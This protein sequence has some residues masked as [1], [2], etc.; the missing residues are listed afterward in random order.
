MFLAIVLTAL[1]AMRV[2]AAGQNMNI[3]CIYLGEPDNNAGDSVLVES[4]GQYLLM[5]LGSAAGYPYIKAFLQERGVTELSLYI[6][7]THADHT[8]GLKDGEGYDSL[9]GDFQV[10]H[11]YLPDKSIGS[12]MDLGWNHGKFVSLYQKHYPSADIS[13]SISYLKTG[14]SFSFGS[15]N[16]SVIGPVGMEKKKVSDYEAGTTRSEAENIYL[17]NCSLVSMLTCGNTRYFSGGDIDT[18]EENKLVSAYGSDLKADIYKMSHHGYANSSTQKIIDC[19]RPTWSFAPNSGDANGF[20]SASTTNQRKVY[21]AL[22]RCS[23]YGFVYLVGAEKMSVAVNTTDDSTKIYRTDNMAQNLTGY[24]AVAGADGK[25]VTQDHY[26]LGADSRPLT[27]V[28]EYN[29][30]MYYFGTG[31]RQEYGLYQKGSYNPWRSYMDSGKKKYR[32]YDK[33]T[34][35]MMTGLVKQS[36][37]KIYFCDTV[38]GY[39]SYGFQTLKGKTYY[40]GNAGTMYKDKWLTYK[41]NRYYFKKNGVMATG[42][43]KVKG[44]RFYF[45]EDGTRANGLTKIGKKYYYMA[46]A[47]TE[48]KKNFTVRADGMVLKFDSKGVLKNAPKVTA[49]KVTSVKADNGKIVVNWKKASKA[50]GYTVYLSSSPKGGFSEQVSVSRNKKSASIKGLAPGKYYV[51]VASYRKIGGMK[52]YSKMSGAKAADM[53]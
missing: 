44:T 40:F 32:Y 34:H 17:N 41:K 26:L 50:S 51:K 53:Q 4:N 33:N 23:Q 30:K 5:D 22:D 8:G 13:Q 21:S 29:G 2:Q 28:Q 47:G 27:G 18:D 52:F 31:G 15:V 3:Y 35:E 14:S 20:T 10:D 24:V 38:T 45:N 7:H 9:L 12:D 37:G 25:N 16:V 43:N 19:I 48:I 39:R 11:V 49:A 6:S 36:A 46:S 42:W 1:P